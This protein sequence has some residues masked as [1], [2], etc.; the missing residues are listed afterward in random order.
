MKT[1]YLSLIAATTVL[2]FASC[3][4]LLDIPQHGVLNYETYYQTDEEAETATSAIYLNV[5]GLEYN[6]YLGK[7]LLSDDFWA[8]G[9][10]RN[11]NAELEQLNEFTFATD[12]S[13]LQGMFQ[14][15]YQIIYKA[16]VVLGHVTGDS[17][18]MQRSRAEAKVFRAWAYFDLITMWGNPPFV[19]H[20][21]EP[22]EYSR[23]NGTTEELWAL[24]EKDL[25]EAIGSGKLPEKSSVNDKS[26]WR[27]TKQY[28]QALLGKA[29]L[30]QKKYDEA[31][32]TFN[33]VADSKLYDLYRGE[34]EDIRMYDNKMNCESMFESMHVDDPEN[35]MDNFTMLPVMIHWRTDCLNMP[36][37]EF[38][39]T[40]WGFA[41]PRKDLYDAFVE[42]EGENGI[43]LNGTMKTYSQMKDLGV[44]VKTGSTII[45]EGYFMWKSRVEAGSV[46]SGGF[47]DFFFNHSNFIWMRYAEVLLLASEANLMAG[48]QGKADQYLNEVRSRAGLQARTATLEAIQT[49]KRLELCGESVRFQD[50]LRWG[51]AENYLKNQGEH[52]PFLDSN[53]NVS[54]KKFNGDDASRYGFKEKHKLLPYPGLEIRL[55]SAIK[56]NPGW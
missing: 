37:G 15:Y 44:S 30:W 28:A 5:R 9:G 13:M 35:A 43:R 12:Q 26:T 50:L 42:E 10:G 52:I 3:N 47:V 25:T 54:Y 51:L 20:E 19:D 17:Y 24:V 36:A 7:N 33:E 46:Q 4:K 39:S 8:G 45:S 41:N 38:L 22:S 21:L 6:Y 18:I 11:D 40:G 34:Y 16:N 27:V 29:Y 1:E 31:A 32:Q 48:N 55:N 14:S 53:G 56:Q 23:P 49:E 2:S